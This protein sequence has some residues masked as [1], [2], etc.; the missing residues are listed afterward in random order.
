MRAKKCVSILVAA[1]LATTMLTGCP[2]EKEEAETD[3]ASSV[4]V[5]SADTSQ[6]DDD[7]DDST[8]PEKPSLTITNNGSTITAGGSTTIQT[9]NGSYALTLNQSGD[10]LTITPTPD[11]KYTT[12]AV[13]ASVT[14]TSQGN[15]SASWSKNEGATRARTLSVRADTNLKLTPDNETNPTKFTLTGIPADATSCSIDV[16]FADLGYVIEGDTYKVHNADGLKAFAD[17]VN[18]GKTGL[19]CTLTANITLTDN[20]TPIGNSFQNA[21]AGTFD[22]GGYTIS[23]LNIDMSNIHYVGLFGYVNGGT[24]ENLNLANVSVSGY[25]YVGGVVGYNNGTIQGCMV[26]GSVSGVDHVGGVVGGNPSTVEGCCFADGSVRASGVNGARV[27]GV[28]GYNSDTVEGCCFAGDS[29]NGTDDG[30]YVGGVVGFSSDTITGCYW[31]EGTDGPSQGVGSGNDDTTKVEGSNWSQ[32]ED[33]LKQ[34]DIA[35]GSDG[36]P[37]PSVIANRN[38]TPAVSG[39]TQRVL[40]AARVFWP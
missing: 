37:V 26:S 11:E 30:A 8:P 5:T 16:T 10:T 14:S 32:Y 21:Y 3:D 34:Y 15:L 23:N 6:D 4:P 31:Q 22:G 12:T 20:W 25:Y 28:V 13:T 2:W 38:N 40:D 39:L 33:D 9:Q 17:A 7:D 35:I 36:K 19:N 29:V 27:G 18:G 24:V 1:S